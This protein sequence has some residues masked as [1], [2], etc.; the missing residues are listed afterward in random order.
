MSDVEAVCRAYGV[1]CE[2]ARG[3]GSH[4]KVFHPLVH[5]ILTIPSRRPIKPV[6]IRRLVRF[7]DSAR[8]AISDGK[9]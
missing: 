6:Y 1:R 3:G 9:A 5:D 8:V 2:P 7:I 4:Y